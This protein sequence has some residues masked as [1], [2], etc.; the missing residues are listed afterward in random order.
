VAF[1]KNAI[2]LL[3]QLM[4]LPLILLLKPDGDL[5]S[6]EKPLGST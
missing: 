6:R 3:L 4:L 1:N 2:H 5:V